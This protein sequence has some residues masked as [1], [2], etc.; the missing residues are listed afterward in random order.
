MNDNSDYDNYD[1]D[2]SWE[3]DDDDCAD[4]LEFRDFVSLCPNCKQQITPEMDSCPFCGDI[5]FRHL[6]DGTFAPRKGYL[7]K[8]VAAIIIILVTLA[9]VTLVLQRLLL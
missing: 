6:K 5:I 4:G 7:A 2:E 8:I 3:P 9:A 1:D